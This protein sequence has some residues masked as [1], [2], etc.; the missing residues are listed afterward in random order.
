MLCKGIQ[1]ALASLMLCACSTT[2]PPLACQYPRP[3]ALLMTRPE[4]LK[5]LPA[6]SPKTLPNAAPTLGASSSSNSGSKE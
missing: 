4:P 2:P 1:A 3:P 6:S 5:Q